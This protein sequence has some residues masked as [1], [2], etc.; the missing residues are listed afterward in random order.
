[1]LY[2]YLLVLYYHG[3]LYV[4]EGAY[5]G[6]RGFPLSQRS[7]LCPDWFRTSGSGSAK[8][9][10]PCVTTTAF[11]TASHRRLIERTRCCVLICAIFYHSSHKARWN[12]ST[13]AGGG[14]RLQ[15][16]VFS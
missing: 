10:T 2:I 13:L 14:S 1:M 9:L 6:R 12:W 11:K 8:G 4:T 15:I 7:C 5:V 16:L 3:N